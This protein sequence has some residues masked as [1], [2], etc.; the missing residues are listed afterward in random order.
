[1]P[2]QCFDFFYEEMEAEFEKYFHLFNEMDSEM[3][4]I[5]SGSGPG[6]L[7]GP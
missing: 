6:I 1:M 3:D 4:S 5:S 2:S 7:K